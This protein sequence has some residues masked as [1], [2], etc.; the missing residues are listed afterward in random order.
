M[1]GI[2]VDGRNGKLIQSVIEMIVRFPGEVFPKL[3]EWER[4]LCHLQNAK[5]PGCSDARNKNRFKICFLSALRL[6]V[7]ASLRSISLPCVSAPMIGT[8]LIIDDH[9]PDQEIDFA[10]CAGHDD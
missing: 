9:R 3:A 6:S 1:E 7:P 5:G 10:V 4:C 8:R 2:S